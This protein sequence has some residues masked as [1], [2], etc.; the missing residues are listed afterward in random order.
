MKFLIGA[1]LYRIIEKIDGE[2]GFC[3]IPYN[4][5]A[6]IKIMILRIFC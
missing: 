5:C 3:L 4:F 1:R 2:K 6:K